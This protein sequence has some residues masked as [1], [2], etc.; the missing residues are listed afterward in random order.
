MYEQHSTRRRGT[1]D[2]TIN[3]SYSSSPS[4]F[5]EPVEYGSSSGYTQYSQP[6]IPYE[7][8]YGGHLESGPSS[9]HSALSPAYN[10]NETSRLKNDENFKYDKS[11]GKRN[12]KPAMNLIILVGGIIVTLAVVALLTFWLLP[13]SKSTSVPSAMD[14]GDVLRRGKG[15]IGAT[16]MEDVNEKEQN[17]ARN[18]RRLQLAEERKAL[19]EKRKLEKEAKEQEILHAKLKEE[20]ALNEKRQQTQENDNE[21]P[22]NI[23]GR[24]VRRRRKQNR[25][26]EEKKVSFPTVLFYLPFIV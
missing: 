4:D 2:Q 10:E 9:S 8:L 26:F 16:I 17:D 11:K 6:S 1:F 7:N 12:K 25:N 20:N 23:D 18:Q 5:S 14:S 22:Q 21:R 19:Y 13:S 24:E 15:N 3:E